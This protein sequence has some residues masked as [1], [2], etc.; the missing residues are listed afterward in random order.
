MQLL[1]AAAESLQIYPAIQLAWLPHGKKRFEGWLKRILAADRFENI[2]VSLG[3]SRILL[4]AVAQ[5]LIHRH[6][7]APDPA[8]DAAASMLPKPYEQTEEET[9]GLVALDIL[10]M[11]RI[12]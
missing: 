12:F 3:N 10:P 9:W 11:H 5:I 7:A 6:P 4:T 2:P 8:Q 1:R